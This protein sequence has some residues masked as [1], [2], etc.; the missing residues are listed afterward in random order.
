MRL[1]IVGGGCDD[2]TC[3]TL[4]ATDRGTFVVQGSRVTDPEALA[5]VELPAHEALVEVPAELLARRPV[6]S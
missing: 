1:T 5:S 3:P 2:G 4:Y 6:Q